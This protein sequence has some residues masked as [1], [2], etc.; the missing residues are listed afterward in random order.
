MGMRYA[1]RQIGDVTVL[2][3]S[4]RLSLYE[5]LAFEKGTVVVLQDVVRDQIAR[6]HLKILI[7]LADVSY[8]DSS[9]LVD[10]VFCVGRL[11]N[12]GG[13]MRVCNVFDR[14]LDIQHAAQLLQMARLESVLNFDRDEDAALQAFARY[15]RP[16]SAN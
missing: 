3:L 7:N 8:L 13:Q 12:Q 15:E 5:S 4:G 6:G 11:R 14:L 9:G 16:T 2:D 1:V 10:L